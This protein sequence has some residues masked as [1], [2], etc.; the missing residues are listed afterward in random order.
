MGL[1]TLITRTTDTVVAATTSAARAVTAA[2]TSAAGATGG[3]AL[4]AGLGAVRGAGL[5]AVRGAADGLR[6]DAERGSRSAPRRPHRHGTDGHRHSGLAAGARRRRHR[7]PGQ[8]AHPAPGR[9]ATT[10][11]GHTPPGKGRQ[12]NPDAAVPG[13]G[14]PAATRSDP[15]TCT[16]PD[17]G[18]A[19]EP[20]ARSHPGMVGAPG[21]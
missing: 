15:P 2:T 18:I 19:G 14:G 8:P 4:G 21:G 10:P 1:G 11:A 12:K 7:L 17:E 5:G 6:D 20:L 3:A 16:C 13:R 9:P